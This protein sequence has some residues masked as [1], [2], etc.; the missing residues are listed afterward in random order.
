MLLIWGAYLFYC[1]NSYYKAFLSPEAVIT[2]FY[3]SVY[4]SSISIFSVFKNRNRKDFKSNGYIFWNTFIKGLWYLCI[5]KE[6]KQVPFFANKNDKTIVLFSIVKLFFIPIMINFAI[7]NF[8]DFSS[9]INHIQS[10][11]INNSWMEILNNVIYPFTISLFFLVDTVL[12]AFGYLF[13]SSFL[14]NRIRSVDAT[15]GGWIAALL[16]YPPINEVLSKIAPL[17]SSTF[18]LFENTEQTFLARLTMIIL[19]F[20]YVSASVSLGSKC[21]NL[22]NRGIVTKGAYS[23]VRHPAYISKVLFWWIT[24]IPVMKNS[25]II[26]ITMLVWTFVYFI[27]AVT[28][29]RHLSMDDDYIK[30]CKI[31]KYRFI[32]FI[33]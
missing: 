31:V 23:F 13:E 16:C 14:K 24:I 25:P 3:V 27:R 9:E 1:T 21:S 12:F 6:Q 22:T 30:Y 19:L 5:R 28:E 11:S 7:R 4:F 33:Y 26:I 18:V 29:E 20:F 32:P 10:I 2:L 17:E 15:W 8:N